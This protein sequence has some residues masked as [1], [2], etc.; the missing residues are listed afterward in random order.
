M[1][2]LM[3]GSGKDKRLRRPEVI[4]GAIQLPADP[5]AFCCD[6]FTGVLRKCHG[7]PEVL[8][9]IFPWYGRAGPV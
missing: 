8:P 7:N 1:T 2:V 6:L 3:A 9:V 5:L 4:Q